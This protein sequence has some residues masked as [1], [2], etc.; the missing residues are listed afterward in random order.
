M[1]LST[2]Q[3]SLLT[4][5]S[6]MTPTVA[7]KMVAAGMNTP[8]DIIDAELS[9]ADIAAALGIPVVLAGLIRKAARS[10]Y[11][12][13]PSA[14]DTAAL[15]NLVFNLASPDPVVRGASVTALQAK[16]M[17][18]VAH[19]G[20]TLEVPTTIDLFNLPPDQ[21]QQAER[22]CM[23]RNTPLVDITT[24]KPEPVMQKRGPFSREA[25]VEKV[26]TRTGIAWGLLADRTLGLAI[27]GVAE[28]LHAGESETAVFQD[29]VTNGPLSQ[30]V[31]ARAAAKGLTDDQ[32][33]AL[34]H[35]RQTSPP[36]PRDQKPPA[37]AKSREEVY[38]DLMLSLYGADELRRELRYQ[39]ERSDEPALVAGLPGSN[40]SPGTL[41]S[42][43]VALLY[44][45]E[46]AQEFLD[47]CRAERPR[48]KYD[49][50]I[51]AGKMGLL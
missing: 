24:F 35:I 23:F 27:W 42:E 34:T 14:A 33:I 22:D 10:A 12:E 9:A 5:I 41:A 38:A 4:T 25:L 37:R 43:A 46:L 45:L 3:L 47:R 31:G 50:D 48:R 40:C 36:P 49:I 29:F 11:T 16:G 8:A 28:S 7:D 51:A 15:V 30:R 39:S 21:R 26:D 20:N 1:T 13:Q 17:R 18:K 19:K 44:R 2:F 32:L 6:G